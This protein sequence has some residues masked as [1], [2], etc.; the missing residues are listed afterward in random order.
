MSLTDDINRLPLDEIE[1]I[2][3]LTTRWIFQAVKDFGKEAFEIFFYSPDDVKDVA[4]DITREILDRLQGFNVPS[5]RIFGTVDYKKARYIILPEK[6]VR[7]ALFVDSKA[8]KSSRT[9]TLQM[10]QTSLTIKQ[11]RGNTSKEGKGTLQP[12]SIYGEKQYL[13]TTAFLH[14][15]YEDID[16]KHHLREITIF[17]LPNGFLQEKY[18]P[19]S[20]DSIWLAGRNAPSRGEDFRVRVCFNKLKQKAAWRVQK[21]TY[22][23][24]T[25]DCQGDWSE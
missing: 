17:S 16:E 10:S 13:T 24:E 8:E 21:V 18:N 23:R 1:A 20:D 11:R 12:I 22:D 7:Q 15:F 19:S 25:H 9:A 5:Q 2:E 14:F 6:M 3:K 4:E